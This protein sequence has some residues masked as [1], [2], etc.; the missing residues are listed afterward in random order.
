MAY[1]LV[2]DFK[3]GLDRRRSM[4]TTPAGSLWECINAHISRG[5]E[6]EKRKAFVSKYSLPA[7]ETFGLHATGTALYTFGSAASPGVPAGVTYQRLQH[8]DGSTAMSAILYTENFDGKV[9]AIAEFTD[10]N[11][12][13]YYNGS[14]VTTW[15]GIATSVSSNNQVANA[16]AIKINQEAD[17]SASATTNVVTIT[18]A[19]A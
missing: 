6:I 15:D 11:I 1:V 12:Y 7:G 4:D 3:R 13:H 16:L 2:E 19:V 10:G 18:A 9:Y 5:G 8:P 17:Y 14:R